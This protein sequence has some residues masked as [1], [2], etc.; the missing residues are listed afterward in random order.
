MPG[1]IC[2]VLHCLLLFSKAYGQENSFPYRQSFEES[3]ATGTATPFLPGWWGNEVAAS[4]RI[5]QSPLARSGSAALAA[6]PTSSFVADIRLQLDTRS[7]Q[8]ATL[9]FWARGARNGSGSRP[10]Q[11]L[12]SYSADGGSTFSTP[13][14]VADF[15][16]ADGSYAYFSYPLPPEL[17][18]LP[19]AVIR[20]QVRRS[21][22]GAG[23]AAR[24][25]LDDVLV[26]AATPRLQLLAAEARS[27]QELVLTFNLPV[28]PASAGQPGNYTL[29]PAVPI[30]AA[31]RST[32]NPRQVVLSTGRL[33]AGTYSL[34][35]TNLL[36]DQ[37]G[38]PLASATVSFAYTAAPQYR[39]IVIN[40]L[41]A[42]P[43]P[44]GSL[45]PQPV[46]LPTEATAEFVELF[47]AS[48][49]AHN[50]Q[51]LRLS[52]GR[53]PDYVLEPG[54]YVLAVPAG[55]AALFAQ[56]GPVVEVEAGAA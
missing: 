25:L 28:A 33:Q 12:L 55:K 21:E 2:L 20:W 22:E 46:V 37:G 19:D 15:A 17:M 23:T 14:L 8:G 50:L 27:A 24:I 9:S 47:N 32:S 4:S 43:N 5:F 6:E 13:E 44:K 49:E 16:N 31:Q 45:R 52:G 29:S 38:E 48:Q 11:L 34:T 1:L 51:Q 54:A 53:L 40:E 39:D 7:L 42:D 3:F 10:S 56:W 30:I 26:E 36:P 41:F 35:V 18:Q